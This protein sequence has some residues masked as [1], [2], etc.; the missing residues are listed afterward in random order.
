MAQQTDSQLGTSAEEIRVETTPSANTANRVG[1]LLKN[2]N[3]SKINN[4]KIAQS[5]NPSPYSSDLLV[6][7]GLLAE[8]VGT[9]EIVVVANYSALPDV[10]ENNGKFYWCSE[11]QGT[12]WLPGSLGG[13]YYS[14]GLYYSNGTTWEYLDVPYNA[15]QAEVDTGTNDD[16]FVTPKTLADSILAVFTKDANDNVFY[17]GMESQVT[18]GTDSYK[19]IFY[20]T[21]GTIT[22]GEQCTG[23]IFEANNHNIDLKFGIRLK[24]VTIKAGN[25]PAHP[26]AGPFDLT[27]S[28]YGF[29]YNQVYPSEIFMGSDN[30]P[31]HKYYDGANDRYV[32]TNLLNFDV[33]YIGGASGG[34]GIPKATASGTDTY[35]A[36]ISGVASYTDGD[37]YLIRFT[38]GNTDT[39]TLNINSLGAKTL[40]ANTSNSIIGGDIWAGSELLC[41]YNS[42][43]NGFQCIGTSP[44]SLFAYVVNADSVAIT[45]GQPV[46]AFGST[47]NRMSVKLANNQSDGTSA[48]TYGLVYSTSIAAGQKGIIIIQGVLT[49]LNLGGTWADGDSVYLGA[50]AGAITKTKP[51]APEHLVYLGVVERA[52]AGNG[53]MY[54]RVQNGYELQELHNV[55]AQSPS[56]KD[57]LW[58]DSTVSPGQWKTSSIATILGYTPISATSTETLTNKRITARTATI[59]SSATPTINTDNV[60]FF[61]ITALAVAIT[62]FTTNLSGTPTEGQTLWI[63]ITDNGTARAI[64][65]GASFESSGSIILPTTTVINTRLDVAFI[66]NTVTSKWR[67]VGVA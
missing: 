50:T 58:Y 57:I 10:S 46:Y 1:T 17:K 20:K 26:S 21:E 61:S 30:V 66:W 19:N 14:K 13:T 56:L 4:D 37:A 6:T 47:G 5:L 59:T 64:T 51:S 40:Y 43:L 52:N 53:I 18:L 62:S 9:K 15:T 49:G 39:S 44:N 2:I 48:Q 38:N 27:G 60:D 63:A 55:Q 42:T 41:I 34:S 65:W 31:Y 22:L 67:C 11:S 28:G 32:V 3:D 25:Y 54:V 24:N 35:T 29:I 16:K 36:T 23:N 7:L 45:R 8:Y 33:A 12:S